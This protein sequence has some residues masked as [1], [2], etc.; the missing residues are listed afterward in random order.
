M[1]AKRLAWQCRRHQWRECGAGDSP[2]RLFLCSR[3]R[4]AFP[5]GIA[6]VTAVCVLDLSHWLS[7]SH[8]C[9]CPPSPRVQDIVTRYACATG[10]HCTR[11][12]GWDCHG[13]PVE[14]EIDK[15]LGEW[16]GLG[17]VVGC[18]NE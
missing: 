14:Y 6:M 2:G 12:F 8:V 15:K 1:R 5:P 11:R 7:A 13:L 3:Q 18:V 4:A 16:G 9:G 10:H 17:V